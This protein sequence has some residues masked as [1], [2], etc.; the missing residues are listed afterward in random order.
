MKSEPLKQVNY[1]YSSIAEKY[2]VI[3][4]NYI[5]AVR[6]SFRH[7]HD[8]FPGHWPLGATLELG[9][10]S[11]VL[12]KILLETQERI[13]AIDISSPML[14][15][16]ESGIKNNSGRSRLQILKADAVK[17]PG[18]LRKSGFELIVFWGNGISHISSSDYKDL[19][20]GIAESLSPG[21]YFV[22]NYRDG[23]EWSKMKGAVEY[24]G[25]DKG[26]AYY[27]YMFPTPDRQGDEM[28]D[29]FSASIFS[30][31][32]NKS[33]CG[34]MEVFMPLLHGYYFNFQLFS[35]CLKSHNLI[36]QQKLPTLG[37][38]GLHTAV[39]KKNAN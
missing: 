29:R 28:G 20:S 13:V 21:G 24:L 23:L 10:G 12:T 35:E 9:C 14:D 6:D 3:Y 11:G 7:F 2:E 4:S 37:M 36:L 8:S 31:S 16:L 17:L 39:F 33:H 22:V 30:V 34:Q 38:V 18:K 15:K 19:A 1:F 25:E 27:F 5:H 26:E 32:K